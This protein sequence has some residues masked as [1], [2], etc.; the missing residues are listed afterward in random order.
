[1]VEAEGEVEGGIA[2]R[3]AFGV[4]DHRAFGPDQDVLG[5]DIAVDQRRAGARPGGVERVGERGEARRKVGV[6]AGGGEEVG[7]DA[8][9]VE[10]ARVA[11]GV[12]SKPGAAPARWMRPTTS[13]TRAPSAGSTR[14]ARSSAFQRRVSGS[15]RYSIAK[16]SRRSE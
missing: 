11:E 1:M 2:H 9:R 7:F 15:P 16:P 8:E 4:E 5:A 3:G 12:R 14:P 13:P 6:H 10:V